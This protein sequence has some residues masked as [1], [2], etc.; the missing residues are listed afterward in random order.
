M[1]TVQQ[2]CSIPRNLLSRLTKNQ[3]ELSAIIL[4]STPKATLGL[5][6][7][8]R[9]GTGL[10]EEAMRGNAVRSEGMCVCIVEEFS[11]L[12]TWP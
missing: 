3:R 5:G 2:A 9:G 10:G 12:R 1:V 8:A 6:A 4:K 7:K 11:R